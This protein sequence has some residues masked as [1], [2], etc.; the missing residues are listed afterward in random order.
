MP[1]QR[2]FIPTRHRRRSFITEKFTIWCPSIIRMNQ[3]ADI[4]VRQ[5]MPSV[6]CMA[7]YIARI[8][9]R[10]VIIPSLISKNGCV[11]M[12]EA[13]KTVAVAKVFFSTC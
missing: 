11:M 4:R 8:W 13:K 6:L 9:M 7:H 5:N 3:A 10:T 2:E 1:E 12:F